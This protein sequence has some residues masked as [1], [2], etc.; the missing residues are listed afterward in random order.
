VRITSRGGN[1]SFNLGGLKVVISRNIPAVVEGL[2][3]GCSI[4]L[5]TSV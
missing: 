5:S 4:V 1:P 2:I 3:T